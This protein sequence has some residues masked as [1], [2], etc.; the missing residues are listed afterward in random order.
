M[1][2]YSERERLFGTDGIR[3]T[4][5][6]YPLTDGM[7][8]KIG[9]SIAKII[10][11]K[12][13]KKDAP[14]VVI[15]RDT[16]LTGR[17]IEAI[18]CDALNFYSIDVFSTGVITTPALS[19]LVREIGVD[20]GIMISASHNKPTD[21]GIKFFGPEG[22]K[23]S[24]EEEEWI[25]NIIFSNLIHRPTTLRNQHMG[26]VY[27]IKRAQGQYIN[28]LKSTVKDL[29]LENMH[30]AIDCGWGAGS[31]IAPRLYRK[32]KANVTSIHDEPKGESINIG[33]A[34]D[35]SYLSKIV[36]QKNADIGIALD[37]D[38][39]RCI[40]VDEKGNIL[41]GDYILAIIADY[42]IKKRELP[43]NTIV[44]TVMNNFG[45]RL[46]LEEIGGKIITT[47]VGDKYVLKAL[48]ENGLN[49]GGEQSGHIIFL[50]YLPSPDGLLTSLQVLRVLKEAGKPLSE[51]AG[52]MVKF[53]QVL[54]NVEVRKK[55]PFSD[56][57]SV[58]GE[59]DYFNDLLKGKGRILLRYSGTENVARVMVEGKDEKLIQEIANTLAEAIKK[60]IGTAT[61]VNSE[62]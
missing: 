7:I 15:G 61:E 26:K 40:L 56:M 5:G 22:F 19:F 45:L 12:R 38:G 46:F 60:E 25:E 13:R 36:L 21:N 8:F 51:I 4:P 53:P 50:D 42:L 23:L 49:I 62:S 31:Q 24:Y 9:L 41:D 2:D 16:R 3:G 43:K 32:L 14:R 55:I 17:R 18:L 28:F 52:R 33:G 57:P 37:G 34:L 29:T 59:L 27:P 58:Y 20:M 6:F 30:I 54:V 10:A 39:D 44:T 48:K 11:Y 35:P 47:K 1:R